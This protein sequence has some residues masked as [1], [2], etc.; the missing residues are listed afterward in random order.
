[1]RSEGPDFD[2]DHI[3]FSPSGLFV[4][5]CGGWSDIHIWKLDW[6]ISSDESTLVQSS[7]FIQLPNSSL[8]VEGLCWGSD[9]QDFNRLISWDGDSVTLWLFKKGGHLI[10]DYPLM[11]IVRAKWGSSDHVLVWTTEKLVILVGPVVM[12]HLRRWMN[13]FW[14]LESRTLAISFV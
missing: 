9:I 2:I 13:R 7:P 11:G 10:Y 4:A 6:N 1:M 8:R 12:S 14:S 5:F 3:I